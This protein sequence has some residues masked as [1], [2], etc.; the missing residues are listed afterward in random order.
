MPS[1]FTRIIHGER[2]ARF[3]YADDRT[4]AF[5]TIAPL[6]PGHTLVVTRDEI[7]QWIDV[8]ADLAAHLYLVAQHVGRAVL[9]AFPARRV[10]LVAAGFEVPHVHLHVFPCDGLEEFDFRRADPRP[11]PAMLDA[12]AARIRAALPAGPAPGPIRR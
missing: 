11:D 1:V 12:A 10:G 5:L 4:V 7:D 8:P 3:G 9:T 6:R 2:P